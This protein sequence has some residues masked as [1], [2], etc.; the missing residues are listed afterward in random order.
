[1]RLNSLKIKGMRQQARPSPKL[2]RKFEWQK[3]IA[4]DLGAVF[5]P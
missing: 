5:F 3:A 2:F 1:M 4:G